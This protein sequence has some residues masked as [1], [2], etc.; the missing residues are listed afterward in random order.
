MAKKVNLISWFG[1]KY[2]SLN[3]LYSHIPDAGSYNLFVDV[4]GGSGVVSLNYPH[5][6]KVRI[7]NDVN[8]SVVNLFRVIRDKDKA[9][10]LAE[11]IDLT[12][13]ARDEKYYCWD[14]YK[15]ETLSDVERAR[16]FLVVI[17]QGF[18]AKEKKDWAVSK[19]N[20]S[21]DKFKNLPELILRAH[22]FIK[23]TKIEN[24]S[25]EHIFKLCDS[26]DS[27]F[28][29]D[30]PYL[31]MT[32][33]GDKYEH[34]MTYDDHLNFLDACLELE[35]KCMISGYPSDLYDDVLMGWRRVETKKTKATE[36]GKNKV[37]G[38][39]IPQATEVLWMNY[40]G[41]PE[42]FTQRQTIDA[43]TL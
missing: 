20:K 28:Y 10:E 6:D 7:Y 5:R 39:E 17:E 9:Q 19:C 24:V 43:I 33:K 22:E 26:K 31:P 8:Q 2:R 41:K 15:D 40:E 13:F 34:D 11:L 35:G 25:Y 36:A 16:M 30:P 37:A 38:A 32:R 23:S 4:F 3:W 42:L 18:F 21:F 1:G 14:N 29:C 27:F 12:P